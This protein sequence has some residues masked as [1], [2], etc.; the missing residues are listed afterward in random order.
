M[1]HN[2]FFRVLIIAMAL[3]H[4]L[5]SA[6][7]SPN[8]AFNCCPDICVDFSTVKPGDTTAAI[9]AGIPGITFSTSNPSGLII[10]NSTNPTCNEFALGSPNKVF[11]GKGI[12]SGGASGPCVNNTSL[13]N[14]LVMTNPSC[15][16]NPGAI[17]SPGTITLVF[18][19]PVILTQVCALN[20]CDSSSNIRMFDVNNNLLSQQ[21]FFA[22]GTNGFQA[23]SLNQPSVK[24]LEVFFNGQSALSCVCFRCEV[25]DIAAR[26]CCDTLS[27]IIN[28]LVTCCDS[29]TSIINTLESRVS[30][31]ETCCE[32][33]T[34]AIEAL[35]TCCDANTRAISVLDA[36]CANAQ[37]RLE[38]LE[39]PRCCPEICVDFNAFNSGANQ[40]IINA[41][42]CGISVSAVGNACPGC[43][44]YVY[45][46]VD[47]DI[48]LSPPGFK[49]VVIS[50]GTPLVSN[51]AGGTIT[52][53]FECP[54]AID[55]VNVLD[56]DAPSTIVLRDAAN[57]ILSTVPFGPTPDA[58]IVPVPVNQTGVKTMEINLADSGG[59]ASVCFHCEVIDVA[60]RSC[61][62][63]ASSRI[64]VLE[65]CCDQN[66]SILNILESQIAGL[67]TC[68]D[69]SRR[70]CS[71]VERQINNLIS[72]VDRGVN[73]IENLQSCCD[74]STSLIAQLET[75]CD[76][77]SSR[78]AQLETCCDQANSRLDLLEFPNCCPF[79]L[80][81]NLVGLQPGDTQAVINSK[82]VGVQIT[83]AGFNGGGAMIYDSSNPTGINHADLGT[84]NENHGG[85]GQEEDGFDTNTVAW[86]NVLI[87]N[88]NVLPLKQSADLRGGS[89]TFTFTCAVM[90][91]SIGIVDIEAD[92]QPA[93]ITLYDLNNNVIAVIPIPAMNDNSFQR[94]PIN[95]PNVARMVVAFQGQAAITDVCYH[96]EVVDI[97][98]RS[99]CEFLSSIVE[100][101]GTRIENLESCCD[102]VRS[103]LDVLE[104]SK[105]CNRFC[106]DFSQFTAGDSEATVNSKLSG[107][108]LHADL[109]A[110]CQ[111]PVQ[112]I[113]D[114]TQ[115]CP[116][117]PL[118]P[119]EF[120]CLSQTTS[121][122]FGGYCGVITPTAQCPNTDAVVST[123]LRID[124]ENCPVTLE[125]LGIGST[126]G[127]VTLL[128]SNFNVLNT[129]NFAA[130]AATVSI[131]QVDVQHVI[132][133]FTPIIIQGTLL[134]P[135]QGALV[136]FCY[137]C[138][139]IDDVARSCCDVLSSEVS[140][141]EQHV[142]D[143]ISC[144]DNHETRIENLESC[145]DNHET[146][147]EN[148][149]S[150]CDEVRS[151]LDALECQCCPKRFCIDFTKFTP[152]D[153]ES[154][155]NSQLCGV[156]L[157]GAT[158]CEPTIGAIVDVTTLGGPVL[159]PDLYTCL[160]ATTSLVFVQLCQQQ[161]TNTIYI[162]FEKCP[163]FL[164][165]I[166]LISTGG[167]ITM[168]DAL[169]NVIKVQSFMDGAADV[170]INQPGVQHVVITFT[171]QQSVRQFEF[172]DEEDPQAAGG[173]VCFC[174]HCEVVD[175]AARSCCETL[176]S[177]IDLQQT[178]INNLVSCCDEVRSRLDNIVCGSC[179]PKQFCVDFA[180]FVP[181]SNQ[182]IVN[183]ALSQ[184]PGISFD[185]GIV[186]LSPVVTPGQL[187]C[188]SVATGQTF[189]KAIS[190]NTAL[191]I[192]FACP[193]IL[194]TIGFDAGQSGVITLLD[195]NNAIINQINYVAGLQNQIINQAGVK[196]V[197]FNGAAGLSIL[198][199]Y[200]LCFQCETADLAA[201]SCCDSL[202][203]RVVELESCCD[204]VRSRLDLLECPLTC[205]P[206]QCIDFNRFNVG[207]TII[208]IN[209]KMCDSI[210]F[211]GNL[212][213]P[214]VIDINTFG[215]VGTV[216]SACLNS[217]S[218]KALQTDVII[219][220]PC[221]VALDTIS[222]VGQ[223]GATGMIDII[224]GN[225]DQFIANIPVSFTS[226]GVKDLSINYTDVG[227]IRINRTSGN[228]G[229]LC[230]CYHCETVDLAARSCCD[231]HETRI[232]RL[233]SCCDINASRIDRLE[234][235]CP[236]EEIVFNALQMGGRTTT[237]PT[238]NINSI[239]EQPATGLWSWIVPTGNNMETPS[240]QL[241]VPKDFDP[242]GPI[243]V[244]AHLFIT[245][246]TFTGTNARMRL[247]A[248]FKSNSQL[249]GPSYEFS[250]TTTNITIPPAPPIS[251]LKQIK[252]TFDLAAST[253]LISPQDWG[254]LTFDRIATESNYSRNIYLAAVSFRYRSTSNPCN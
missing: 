233:E 246:Q 82:L 155:V 170:H 162:D 197:Q 127:V 104:K 69:Q 154:F 65:T 38:Q 198:R 133:N 42:L 153:S 35:E 238:F 33:N 234:R 60:A 224:N 91:D 138:P 10:F 167:T 18:D 19:C 191:T 134:F 101:F 209:S 64:A 40:A 73:Q 242:T 121:L 99:C 76:V 202:T 87:I 192:T 227:Q 100:N 105:C 66:S 149:E 51:Q 13:G 102:E 118:D 240:M 70:C 175:E 163:V 229:L 193:V 39:C 112:N 243:Q 132:I 120:S 46:A 130:G 179:C 80:N 156:R 135:A 22:C 140:I 137:H 54:V 88:D 9:N 215:L 216:T 34:T 143:L 200:C 114:I 61:C 210:V 125:S 188:L 203:N 248:D 117:S 228:F 182:D 185:S 186:G 190:S 95:T 62:D 204:E 94:V 177:L 131:N 20:V 129:I 252:V 168:Y 79:C 4:G 237:V 55:R 145:C 68:C 169:F 108:K 251:Q 26:S 11:G 44:A 74:Q 150:C 184:C 48:V 249:I 226:T 7:V 23:L 232:E 178:Q 244:D 111:P 159:T 43:Q 75:C 89:I 36:C 47:P 160:S 123:T 158:T 109:P 213:I 71:L 67:E 181:G 81:F 148:L 24:R 85:P 113:I 14:V 230:F 235:A 56:I 236:L 50:N 219:T 141:I 250:I 164:D 6:M 183:A 110:N 5:L 28:E 57:T 218:N 147:I 16:P 166:G 92:D 212:A 78:I 151:R 205:C 96:C 220:F 176:S 231:N 173:L 152:G 98:A 171:N 31:L 86:G 115:V 187:P 139:A 2:R 239:L 144:C 72:V 199:L 107:V 90:V 21:N 195:Q 84:P 161:S 208:T 201:R 103:R 27:S 15:L 77:N 157:Q 17:T 223:N 222:L 122:V 146:R 93:T 206:K 63:Q 58:V 1:K 37:S 116:Q 189:N 165:N 29:N 217:A 124:F 196:S 8:K 59:I 254:I 119:A 106:I 194:N 253:T 225:G 45:N 207:D 241:E 32:A 211:T 3:C 126:G 52:F 214:S 25:V 245:G 53:R 180:Q 142:N 174:Y 49:T 12:G 41:K 136:C 83:A 221:P 128:D 172:Q 30:T 97:A 247:R